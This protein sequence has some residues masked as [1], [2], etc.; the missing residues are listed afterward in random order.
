MGE[1]TIIIIGIGGF[2]LLLILS[3]L[4]R[5]LKGTFGEKRVSHILAKLPKE[6]YE[7]FNDVMIKTEHGTTQI[8]HVVVSH[9]GVFVIETKTMTGWIY[10]SENDKYWTQNIYGNKYQFYNPVFQNNGHVRALRKVLDDNGRIFIYPIVA[11][12]RQASLRI[13]LKESCVIYWRQLQRTI[14]SFSERRLTDEQVHYVGNKL[15]ENRIDTSEK[16]VKEE[17]KKN[18]RAAKTYSKNRPDSMICPKCGGF[19]T[20]KQG[21]YGNFFGCSNYPNCSYTQK[22]RYTEL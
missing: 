8:D 19:L 3:W 22:E 10:G 18:V 13:Y 20:L 5:H 7:V 11:F 9:Y 4:F 6:R 17:H 16:G 12:S 2:I 1:T 21:K 14:E 15:Y